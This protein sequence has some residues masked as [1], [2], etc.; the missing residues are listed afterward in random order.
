MWR[1]P[2]VIG[3]FTIELEGLIPTG[4]TAG[5]TDD[6]KVVG[7]DGQLAVVVFVVGAAAVVVDKGIFD[8]ALDAIGHVLIEAGFHADGHCDGLVVAEQGALA[9]GGVL[10][11]GTDAGGYGLGGSHVAAHL[12][13]EALAATRTAGM[14]AA[15]ISVGLLAE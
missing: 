1:S 7:G 8:G 10:V 2:Q 6:G 3:D 12:E 13:T 14:E 11:N 15:Q 5:I 4:T 9:V